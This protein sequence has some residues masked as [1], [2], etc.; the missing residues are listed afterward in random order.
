[1]A[2]PEGIVKRTKD[3]SRKQPY[4]REQWMLGKKLGRPKQ[5]WV[6][7]NGTHWAGVGSGHWE[8]VN[9]TQ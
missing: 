6:Y 1:M 5:R 7:D 2:K 4:Q 8:K 3:N 9:D